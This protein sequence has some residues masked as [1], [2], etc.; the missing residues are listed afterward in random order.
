MI[1]LVRGPYPFIVNFISFLQQAKGDL[2]GHNQLHQL[3]SVSSVRPRSGS[4]C[5]IIMGNVCYSVHWW[6]EGLKLWREWW[7]LY[8]MLRGIS[9]PI[10]GVAIQL[11]SSLKLM[12]NDQN[13]HQSSAEIQPD[14]LEHSQTEW[15]FPYIQSSFPASSCGVIFPHN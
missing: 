8:A 7:C 14:S 2:I 11:A 4:I 12:Q 3:S 13:V 15:R 9:Q 6:I 1:T 10:I 5:I